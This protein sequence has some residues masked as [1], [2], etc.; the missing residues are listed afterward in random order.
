LTGNG[1]CPDLKGRLEILNVHARNKKLDASV[2]LEAI[3]RRTPGFTGADLANLLNEAAILT[4]RRRKDATILEIDDAVDRVV[5][6]WKAPHRG[7]QEQATDCLPRSRTRLNRHLLK[8]HDP[9]QKVP[10]A[11]RASTGIDMV[12]TKSR[13]AFRSQLKAR[14]TGA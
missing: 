9:V 13:F 3:A 1:R 8:D 12:S 6:G 4:A 2:S 7:Q 10:R 11:T 5:A 14:I